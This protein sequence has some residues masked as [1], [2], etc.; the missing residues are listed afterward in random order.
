MLLVK[1]KLSVKRGLV[2]LMMIVPAF[3]IDPE[4]AWKS[5]CQEVAGAARQS[6]SAFRQ[7]IYELDRFYRA[8]AP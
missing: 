6:A 2:T 3:A 7:S 5:A 1:R 4:T 8:P